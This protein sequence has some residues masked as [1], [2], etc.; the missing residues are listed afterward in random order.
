MKFGN[1]LTCIHPWFLSKLENGR[2]ARLMIKLGFIHDRPLPNDDQWAD[3][4]DRYL[5]KLFRDYVFHQVDGQ[6]KAILDIGHVV[7][8]LNKVCMHFRFIESPLSLCFYRFPVLIHE[9]LQY[10]HSQLDVG[11]DERV[12]LTSRDDETCLIVSYKE[13]KKCIEQSFKELL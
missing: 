12:L 11:V 5:I 8:C 7:S 1:N 13:L 2:L 6:R 9:S 3:T 10:P 4:G